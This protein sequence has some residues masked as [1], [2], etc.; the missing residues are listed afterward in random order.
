MEC[1]TEG[2]ELLCKGP[3]AFRG[4]PDFRHVSVQRLLGVQVHERHLGVADDR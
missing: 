4:F 1:V 3:G 2:E